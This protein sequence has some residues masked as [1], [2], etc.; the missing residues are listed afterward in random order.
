MLGKGDKVFDEAGYL[1]LPPCQ[2]GEEEGLLSPPVLDLDANLTAIKRANNT[3]Y[4]YGVMGI[5]QMRGA[6]V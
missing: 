1:F 3:E 5:W 6:Y 2:W 4:H